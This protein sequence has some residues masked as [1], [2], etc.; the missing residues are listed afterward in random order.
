MIAPLP[1]ELV[2]AVLDFLEVVSTSP[3]L[4][5]LD[6]LISAYCHHVPWESAS[7]IVK[8]ARSRNAAEAARWP[9]VFWSEAMAHGTG[10]TCYESNYAFLSLLQTLGFEGYLTLNTIEGIS[11]GHSAILVYL[12]G[13][14]WLVDVGIPLHTA[15]PV[16]PGAVSQRATRFM[17]YRVRAMH[18]PDCYEI[19]R[20]PHPNLNIYTLID[21]P[22]PEAAYRDA[23]LA[24]YGEH[25][26]F[27]DRVIINRLV[28][29]RLARFSSS[30]QPPCIKTF[31]AGQAIVHP[32]RG[33]V[34]H[35][36]ATYFEINMSIL[37]EA[38]HI[39]ATS[40]TRELRSIS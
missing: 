8:R 34:A 12:N 37:D 19:E 13:L 5:L 6:R 29:E 1:D 40:E 32:I 11:N 18:E 3:D 23:L 20:F 9:E 16:K 36:V 4:R 2:D 31:E 7:R 24:D 17:T 28:N 27:L 30:E 15:I 25:G 35:T 14:K 10:G 38:L 26:L 39:L 21:R 33:N 22:I